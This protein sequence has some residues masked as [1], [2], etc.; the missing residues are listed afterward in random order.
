[1]WSYCGCEC[2]GGGYY[3]LKKSKGVWT[4]RGHKHWIS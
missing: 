1:M 3:L 2:G 4:V